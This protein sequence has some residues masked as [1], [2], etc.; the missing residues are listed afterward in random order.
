MECLSRHVSHEPLAMPFRLRELLDSATYESMHCALSKMTKKNGSFN[1]HTWGSYTPMR[2][3]SSLQL[4]RRIQRV[5]VIDSGIFIAALWCFVRRET[6]GLQFIGKLGCRSY[7][8]RKLTVLP[9]VN[10]DGLFKNNA[11]PAALYTSHLDVSCLS[12]TNS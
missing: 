10:E 6:S 11:S 4:P 3:A 7:S 9:L 5:V 8:E 12:A 2:D 1:Q